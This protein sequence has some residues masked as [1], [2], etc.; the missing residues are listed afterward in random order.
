[1]KPTHI[2]AI[3]AI[4]LGLTATAALAHHSFSAEFDVNKPITLQGTVKRVQWINPHSW[5]WI[6]VKKPDGTSEE[7]GIE[8]GTPNTLFRLGFTREALP[9]GTEIVVSGYEARD[10][11]K[12][13]NGRDMTLPDGRKLLMGSSAGNDA[14]SK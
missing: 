10:G 1:M 5:I 14:Q 8:A 2:A 11:A 3:A 6:D 7:W 4:A 13:A 9:V 12:R